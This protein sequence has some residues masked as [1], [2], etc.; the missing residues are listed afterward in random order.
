MN[1]AVPWPR[2]TACAYP[3]ALHDLVQRC[4]AADP[5]ARPSAEQLV[6]ETAALLRLRPG[7]RQP[8]D[9]CAP[10]STTAGMGSSVTMSS[11]VGFG[12]SSG[13]GGDEGSLPDPLEY[14]RFAPMLHF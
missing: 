8:E 5:A 4:L 10:G 3:P 6:L 12:N 9:I 11:V 14:S 1:G 7:L 2:S 13:P